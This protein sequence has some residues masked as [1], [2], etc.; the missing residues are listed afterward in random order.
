MRMRICF[1]ASRFRGRLITSM[2]YNGN[3]ET[4][5]IYAFE[6]LLAGWRGNLSY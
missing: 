1:N 4:G 3:D 6:G 2:L 5:S